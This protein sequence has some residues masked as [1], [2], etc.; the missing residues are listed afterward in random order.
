MKL[1]CVVLRTH[2]GNNY[3]D[4]TN[5][6]NY[7]FDNFERIDVNGQE[8]SEDVGEILED[9]S[10]E[11]CGYV[12]VPKGVKFSDLKMEMTVDKGNAGEA[13]LIYTYEGN[14]VGS[15]KA[16]VSEKYAKEHRVEIKGQEKKVKKSS[17]SSTGKSLKEM[18]IIVI[19]AVLLLFLIL[20]FIAKLRQYRRK[21]ERR[22]RRHRRR[23]SQQ[24]RGGQSTRRRKK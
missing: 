24:N 10:G 14:V 1:I 16:K 4:T 2:G 13:T 8:T 18:L 22:R 5:L 15:A 6:F 12:V 21:R 7:A 3:P 19:L 9:K 17:D 20:L 11:H 23:S